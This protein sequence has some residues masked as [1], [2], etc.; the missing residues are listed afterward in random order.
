MMR[1]KGLRRA[2]LTLAAIAFLI[3]AQGCG[4]NKVILSDGSGGS[5]GGGSTTTPSGTYTI[6]VSATAAGVTHAVPLTL[7]V[8]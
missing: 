2:L 4:S 6:T 3:T 1:R 5:G 7:K 8:Q